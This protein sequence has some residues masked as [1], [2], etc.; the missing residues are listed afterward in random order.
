V[1]AV[2]QAEDVAAMLAEAGLP[3]E[4]QLIGIPGGANNRVYRVDCGSCSALLKAYF[5]HPGD[6][7]DRLGAEFAFCRFAWDRGLRCLP[8]PL[9]R[10]RERNLGLYEFIEGRI[11]APDE[12]GMPEVQQAVD[13]YQELNRH[14]SDPAAGELPRGSEACFT[15]G[16][17]LACVERRL[18]RLLQLDD[19]TPVGREASLLVRR[20]LAPAWEEVRDRAW[21]QAADWGLAADEPIPRRDECLSPSDFGFHNAILAAD[22]RLRFIDFEYAGWDDPAKTIC[23]FF[24]QPAIPVPGAYAGHYA[25]AVASDLSD[26]QWHLRRVALLLPVYRVKWCC[27]MLNDFLPVDSRRRFFAQDA[28][29]DEGRKRAQLRKAGHAVRQIGR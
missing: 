13:F 12:V 25:R 19:R 2:P 4:F 5:C 9:A 18:D 22:G 20:E 8:R 1:L 10:N 15:L 24:C 26:P 17:H 27:I 3:S 7:R 16:E 23:D 11:L 29:T 14:K 21:S 6:P 28:S